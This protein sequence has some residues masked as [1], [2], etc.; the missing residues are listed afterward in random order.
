MVRSFYHVRD[1]EPIVL[2]AQTSDDKWIEHGNGGPSVW[3]VASLDDAGLTGTWRKQAGI[4]EL[5]ILLHRVPGTGNDNACGGE[6]YNAPF[7]AKFLKL[8]IGP[9]ASMSPEKRYRE[10]HAPRCKPWS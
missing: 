2:E 6:V 3:T 8:V 5:P 9:V 7:E 10:F 1:L 4:D